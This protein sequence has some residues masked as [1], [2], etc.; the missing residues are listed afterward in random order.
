MV[1]AGLGRRNHAVNGCANEADRELNVEA[2]EWAIFI[3]TLE[4][5]VFPHPVSAGT[6][7][8]RSDSTYDLIDHSGMDAGKISWSEH[9]INFADTEGDHWITAR[10]HTVVKQDR[11]RLMNG[12]VT[13]SDGATQIGVYNGG[14]TRTGIEKILW[15]PDL[16]QARHHTLTTVGFY[17]MISACGDDVYGAYS[18]TADDGEARFIFDQ[19]VKDGAVEHV[20]VATHKVPFQSFHTSPTILPV[21]KIRF[22]F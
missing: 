21:P 17:P 8:V 2:Y 4:I 3:V 10:G 16:T 19:I 11:I 18:R 20:H 9:G 1:C 12:L 15:F 14:F 6:L 7:L 5:G 13:L 22:I